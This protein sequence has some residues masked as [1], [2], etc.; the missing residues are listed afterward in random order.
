M[1]TYLVWYVIQPISSQDKDVSDL[2]WKMWMWWI[3]HWKPQNPIFKSN[4]IK[5]KS[6]DLPSIY[7]YLAKKNSV[8][9]TTITIM[10]ISLLD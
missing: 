9:A 1:K 3:G 10:W 5:V 2:M 8:N 6:I 4:K 7:Q